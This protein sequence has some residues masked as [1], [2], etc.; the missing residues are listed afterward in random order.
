MMVVF[1][2]AVIKNKVDLIVKAASNTVQG[3]WAAGS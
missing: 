2:F 1:Q 3:P